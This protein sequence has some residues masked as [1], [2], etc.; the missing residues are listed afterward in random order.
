MKSKGTRQRLTNVF[1][2]ALHQEFRKLELGEPDKKVRK[3]IDKATKLIT[4]EVKRFMKDVQKEETK[5]RNRELKKLRTEQT[6]EKT[7][8]KVKVGRIKQ[9]REIVDDIVA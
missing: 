1:E 7:T 8:G 6:S 4:S 9:D 5:A 3:A 2:I